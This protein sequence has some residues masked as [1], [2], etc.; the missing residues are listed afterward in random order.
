[1]L[2]GNQWLVHGRSS[3]EHQEDI[4]AW[5]VNMA[6]RKVVQLPMLGRGRVGHVCRWIDGGFAMLVGWTEAFAPQADLI[7]FDRD[8]RRKWS[9]NRIH[10]DSAV[11]QEMIA[12]EGISLTRSN[13]IALL[14]MDEVAFFDTQGRPTQSW[15]VDERWGRRHKYLAGFWAGSD[16]TLLFE[17]FDATNSIVRTTA[18]GRIISQYSPQDREGRKL[19]NGRS[20]KLSPDGRVWVTDQ[21]SLARLDA[22]GTTDL[23]IG[24]P[25]SELELTAF[26]QVVVDPFNQIHV[27]DER[28]PT[29]HSFNESG[30]RI[31]IH[32][33]TR[34]GSPSASTQPHLSLSQEGHVYV[35][36]D[37]EWLPLPPLSAPVNHPTSRMPN[38]PPPTASNTAGHGAIPSET[39]DHL[40]LSEYENAVISPRNGQPSRWIERRADGNWLEMV[41][42][43]YIVGDGRF[44][45]RSSSDLAGEWR[46]YATLFDRSGNALAT[47]PLARGT[48]YGNILFDGTHFIYHT[49]AGLLW[50]KTDGTPEFRWA[51]EGH[52]NMHDSFLASS[53][54][55]LWVVHS[56][57]RTVDRYSLPP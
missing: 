43:N 9:Q 56:E 28:T 19:V 44:V 4:L 15:P 36:I 48:S 26:S 20:A 42:G 40:I 32:T 8:G 18:S 29:V 52:A 30:R 54:K 45:L 11:G 35:S 46:S 39:P 14:G 50:A 53:G 55:E 25:P 27:L 2:E 6:S 31:G 21:H 5:I 12:S 24:P 10:G 37:D 7:A 51:P 47:A 23:V 3:K 13:E 41:Q 34:T 49:A 57:T 38:K 22:N 16:G 33:F 17:D 1:W